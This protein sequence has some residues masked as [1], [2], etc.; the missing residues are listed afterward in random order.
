MGSEMCI[1]DSSDTDKVT[2]EVLNS[3]NLDFEFSAAHKPKRK[4]I[5][6]RSDKAIKSLRLMDAD[7]NKTSYDVVGSNLVILPMSDFEEGQEHLVEVKFLRTDNVVVVKVN[8][9]I[10]KE[11]DN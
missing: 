8:V 11:Q 3:D 2:I 10:F 1:R 7:N 6:I 5:M 9:P 4:Q